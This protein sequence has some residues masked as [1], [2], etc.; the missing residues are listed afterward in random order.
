[1]M[2][3][4]L[5]FCKCIQVFLLNVKGLYGS[6]SDFSIYFECWKI[7]SKKWVRRGYVAKKY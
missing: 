1:M 6:K 4:G 2:N 7:L 3:V 5:F